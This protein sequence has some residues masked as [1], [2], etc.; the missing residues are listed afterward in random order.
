[1][2]IENEFENL[3]NLAAKKRALIDAVQAGIDSGPGA[4]ATAFLDHL[5][6]KYRLADKRRDDALLGDRYSRSAG[7]LDKDRSDRRTG[8]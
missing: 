2:F 5:R 4:D 6:Q 8:Q 3:Q 1:M 7:C